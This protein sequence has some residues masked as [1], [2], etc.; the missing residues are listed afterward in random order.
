MKNNVLETV[1]GAVV[2]AIA[3]FFIYL[4]YTSGQTNISSGYIVFA[5][6]DRIDGLSLGNDVKISGVKV[7]NIMKIDIDPSDYQAKVS[8]LIRKDIKLTTDTSAEVVSESLMGGKYV[9]LTPGA[10]E[11]CLS[12]N[13]TITI[14]Q[15]AISFE[16]LIGKFLFSKNGDDKKK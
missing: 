1:L 10:D 8:L 9:S 7:G 5:K 13:D 3:G 16:Q 15:S 4:A 14:T 2:L 11:G 12:P 6:F